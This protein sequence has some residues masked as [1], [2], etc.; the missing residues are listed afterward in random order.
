MSHNNYTLALNYKMFHDAS[1][2]LFSAIMSRVGCI[3]GLVQ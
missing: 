3:C 2:V 1:I